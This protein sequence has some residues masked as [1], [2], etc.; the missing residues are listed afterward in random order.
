M[1]RRALRRKQGLIVAAAADRVREAALDGFEDLLHQAFPVLCERPV[2]RDPGCRGKLAVVMALDAANVLDDEVFLQGVALRQ[3]EPAWGAP[4]DTAG[5]VRTHCLFALLRLH[6]P[7]VGGLVADQLADPV[8]NVR[9]E[10]ARAAASLGG[11]LGAALLRLKVR[12]GDDDSAALGEALAGLCEADED[13]GMRIAGEWLAS[14][15]EGTRELA[16][17]ALGQTRL[18]AAVP[19]LRRA[20]ERAVRARER[21][22]FWV[23][24][25]TLR[26]EGARDVLLDQLDG[27]DVDVVLEALAPYRF[28]RRTLILALDRAPRHLHDKVREAL[29]MD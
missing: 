12:L 20:A 1:L 27:P 14:S 9:I 3:L 18:D 7:D 16:A 8:P 5:P 23:A 10:A 11:S 28:D 6:H 24:L 21:R 22:T 13:V 4:V 2:K 17:L 29:S 19:L 25:G 26:L 15:D